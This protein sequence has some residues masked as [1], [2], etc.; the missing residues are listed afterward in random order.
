LLPFTTGLAHLGGQMRQLLGPS[1]TADAQPKIGLPVQRCRI[2]KAEV[3]CA[4]KFAR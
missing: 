4:F 1:V 3:I 2:S